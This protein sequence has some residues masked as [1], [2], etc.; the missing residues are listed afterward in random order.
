M[1]PASNHANHMSRLEDSIVVYLQERME[2]PV[3][4]SELHCE[5]LPRNDDY[6]SRTIRAAIK[7]LND[8]GV[9]IISTQSGYRLARSSQEVEIYRQGLV[10]RAQKILRRAA[11]LQYAGVV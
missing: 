5:L 2:R 7:R 9:P 4:A 8:Y 6:T 1:R 3:T 11:L 10:Q